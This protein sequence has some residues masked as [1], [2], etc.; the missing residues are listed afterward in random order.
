MSFSRL[1][2][3]VLSGSSGLVSRVGG[4]SLEGVGTRVDVR[5][6]D[7]V[8]RFTGTLAM[9]LSDVWLPIPGAKTHVVLG[10]LG[11]MLILGKG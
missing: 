11:R 3:Y 10:G 1:G 4:C 9:G 2:P 5:M 6:G 7:R 8:G